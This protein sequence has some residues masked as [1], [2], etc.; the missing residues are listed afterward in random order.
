MISALQIGDHD[1]VG[2]SVALEGNAA[3]HIIKTPF[4]PAFCSSMPVETIPLL[5]RGGR[6]LRPLSQRGAGLAAYSTIGRGFVIAF[7]T[8]PDQVPQAQSSDD[9]GDVRPYRCTGIP[10]ALFF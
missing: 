5:P 3:S 8:A 2:I 10:S 6:S 9:K 7:S 1:I 4:P